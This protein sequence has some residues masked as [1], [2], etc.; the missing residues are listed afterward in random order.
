MLIIKCAACKN[1]LWKYEKFGKGEVLRCYKKR[2]IKIYSV[3]TEGEKIKC[4]CGNKI[5]IDKG[6]FI[7]MISKAFTYSGTKTNK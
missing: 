6:G 1:K 7:K 2:I 4:L 5:G 3:E